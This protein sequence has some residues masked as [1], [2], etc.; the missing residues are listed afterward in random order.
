MGSLLYYLLATVLNPITYL[1]DNVGNY[2][3]QKRKRSNGAQDGLSRDIVT[4]GSA[5]SYYVFIKYSK[6]PKLWHN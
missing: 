2:Y 5:V 3:T 6:R 1:R 4:I